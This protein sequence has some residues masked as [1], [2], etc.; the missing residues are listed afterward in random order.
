VCHA[1][2]ANKAL[3]WYLTMAAGGIAGGASVIGNN[4]IDAVKSRM[5]GLNSSKYKNSLDCAIQIYKEAGVVG[6]VA[7]ATYI[8]ITDRT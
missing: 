4:P 1:G 7:F 5:Q 2:D 3:P 6:Y 8:G